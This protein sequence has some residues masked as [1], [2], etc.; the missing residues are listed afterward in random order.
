MSI[1]EMFAYLHEPTIPE[2]QVMNRISPDEGFTLYEKPVHDF[3]LRKL[4]TSTQQDVESMVQEVFL[5]YWQKR[6]LFLKTSSIKTYLFGIAKNVLRE[7][8]RQTKRKPLIRLD[9]VPTEPTYNA[10][11]NEADYLGN[12]KY[13]AKTIDGI[14]SKFS[15]KKQQAIRLVIFN[16]LSLQEAAQEAGCTTNAVQ[17]R[18][19]TAMKQ[20]HEEL[21]Y[22]P[23]WAC[24]RNG[25][26]PADCPAACQGVVCKKF[27]ILN[28]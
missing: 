13:V 12:I 27:E 22:C 24:T 19:S 1:Q 5:R 15:T 7:A 14:L 2:T 3:L 17:H 21:C 25:P 8:N 11:I 28:F 4:G 9:M 18:L 23:P 6:E 16:G 10:S 20:L 26:I